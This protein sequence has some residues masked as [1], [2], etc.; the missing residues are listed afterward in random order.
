MS[1]QNTT[2]LKQAR[3]RKIRSTRIQI[4]E[5]YRETQVKKCFKFYLWIKF[6][7]FLWRQ[8]QKISRKNWKWVSFLRTIIYFL[9]FADI[10]WYQ[11]YRSWEDKSWVHWKVSFFNLYI[12]Y[13]STFFF[14]RSR[15]L[16]QKTNEKIKNYIWLLIINVVLYI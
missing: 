3:R 10:A 11:E 6:F 14:C 9:F 7:R 5:M 12:F 4:Q 15:K 13:L 1:T 8:R 2:A 16:W